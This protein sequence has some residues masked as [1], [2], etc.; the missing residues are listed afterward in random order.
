MGSTDKTHRRDRVCQRRRPAARPTL[1]AASTSQVGAKQ[2]LSPE[3]G[4]Y[5]LFS[6]DSSAATAQKSGEQKLKAFRR[7][8][9]NE[10]TDLVALVDATIAF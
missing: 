4:T 5:G 3:T 6:F 9:K 7:A 1:Q 8:V 2:A 10:L